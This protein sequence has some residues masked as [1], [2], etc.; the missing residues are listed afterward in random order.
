M[1]YRLGGRR[2][3]GRWGNDIEDG[4]FWLD[5]SSFQRCGIVHELAI[6][7]DFKMTRFGKI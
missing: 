4:L 2:M 7:P 5:W 6:R 3:G 1:G